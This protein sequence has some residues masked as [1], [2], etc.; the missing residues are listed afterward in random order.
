MDGG[1]AIGV[2][3]QYEGRPG[4]RAV[5]VRDLGDL[6]GPAQG[7]VRLPLWLYWSGDSPDFDLDDPFMRRWLYEIVLRETGGAEDLVRF[8]NAGLLVAIWPQLFLPE[9][10]RRAWEE[11]HPV[12]RDQAGTAA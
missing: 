7:S 11:F 5:V 6:R 1:G 2:R 10:V 4:R 12:L 3:T 9:G 8:L